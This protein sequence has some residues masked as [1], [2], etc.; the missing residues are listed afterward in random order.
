M[1]VKLNNFYDV[2]YDYFSWLIKHIP[3]RRRYIQLLFRLDHIV[4]TCSD[5]VPNDENRIADAISLRKRYF[6]ECVRPGQTEKD[7]LNFQKLLMRKIPTVL[8]VILALCLRMEDMLGKDTYNAGEWFWLIMENLR[9]RYSDDDFVDYAVETDIEN[10]IEMFLN[11]EY[12]SDGN[13]SAFPGNFYYSKG[14]DARK[15]ELWYQCNWY[16]SDIY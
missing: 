7:I 15:T 14:A 3:D 1:L 13:G 5:V 8:E 2:R 4:F 10:K 6:A 11:R 16:V 12:D 9:I